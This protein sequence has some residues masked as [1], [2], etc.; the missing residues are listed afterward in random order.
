[1]PWPFLST[2]V[3]KNDWG[4][5]LSMVHNK[6]N[7]KE[8]ERFSLP[9][10]NSLVATT[11]NGVIPIL[12]NNPLIMLDANAV[13][14]VDC[15][16]VYNFS[17]VWEVCHSIATITEICRENPICHIDTLYWDRKSLD[18]VNVVIWM[19]DPTA[20]RGTIPSNPR[21]KPRTPWQWYVLIRALTI[22]VWLCWKPTANWLF[23]W[24]CNCVLT[25]YSGHPTAEPTERS[26]M[27]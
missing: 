7:L 11:S 19:A 23:V 3:Q 4:F 10:L 12:R 21:H 9:W 22:P 1:M 6:C 17:W 15:W 27:W 18:I 16:K 26:L 8:R 14:K 2:P 25:M 13:K 20:V 24:A 5:Q